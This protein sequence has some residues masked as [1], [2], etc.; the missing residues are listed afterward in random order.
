MGMTSKEIS[1]IIDSINIIM[2]TEEGT[3]GNDMD[4]YN[5]KN[6]IYIYIYIYIWYLLQY[7]FV[8]AYIFYWT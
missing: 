6:F 7:V 8:T 1:S 3:S 5:G 2:S 4:I